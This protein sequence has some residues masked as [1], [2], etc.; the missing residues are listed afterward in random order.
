MKQMKTK[1]NMIFLPVIFA[2]G[3]GGKVEFSNGVLSRDSSLC[4]F[5][6]QGKFR[7]K[8]PVCFCVVRPSPWYCTEAN[9]HFL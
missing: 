4:S 6:A 8:K 5:L 2:I 1:Q 3:S 7:V 9:K